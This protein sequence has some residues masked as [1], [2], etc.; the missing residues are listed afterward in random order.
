MNTKQCSPTRNFCIH[1]DLFLLSLVVVVVIGVSIY[2]IR[3]QPET[4]SE[5]KIIKENKS[6]EEKM[7][8]GGG[9]KFISELSCIIMDFTQ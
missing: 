2:L 6:K 3:C 9:K 8:E 4:T 5:A 7:L 1:F